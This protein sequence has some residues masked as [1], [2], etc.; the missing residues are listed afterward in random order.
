M[1]FKIPRLK[2][3]IEKSTINKISFKTLQLRK[4]LEKPTIYKMFFKNPRLRKKSLKSPRL[5]KKNPL[6]IHSYEKIDDQEKMHSL[7]KYSSYS[8]KTLI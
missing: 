8:F 7:K 3:V 5:R 6:E 2:K 1:S 4:M